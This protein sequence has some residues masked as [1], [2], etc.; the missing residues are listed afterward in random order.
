ME[1]SEWYRRFRFDILC[2]RPDQYSIKL[3][4]RMIPPKR[5]PNRVYLFWKLSLN[6]TYYRNICNQLAN[7]LRWDYETF[8]PLLD[9]IGSPTSFFPKSTRRKRYEKGETVVGIAKTQG[10]IYPVKTVDSLKFVFG[11]LSLGDPKES[12]ECTGKDR[13]KV[14]E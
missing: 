7:W 10:L 1:T 6:L 14:C 8:Q 13:T 2:M 11:F 4:H 9:F 12:E 3:V 5:V